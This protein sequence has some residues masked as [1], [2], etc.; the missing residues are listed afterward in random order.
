M[1]LAAVML[2][3]LAS[4]C[5][6]KP[7]GPRN[8]TTEYY[9]ASYNASNS[10]GNQSRDSANDTVPQVTG[11]GFTFKIYGVNEFWMKTNDT[12]KFY[13]VFNN[14]DEDMESHMFIAHVFP[15]AADFDVMAAYS[16]MYF[17]TCEPLLSRM[18]LMTDQPEN[19]TLVNYGHV[20]LYSIGIRIPEGTPAG[21]YMYNMVACKDVTFAECT[22]TSANF[23]SNIPVIVHVL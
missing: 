22:E 11:N 7:A 17:T 19:S 3:V 12:T 13:V 4:G 10:P 5:T 23:G 6:N 18:R 1:V 15:S 9:N 16:C 20:N 8:E 14:E 21:T 2:L